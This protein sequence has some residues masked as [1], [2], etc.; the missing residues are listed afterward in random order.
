MIEIRRYVLELF[1]LQ[2][3]IKDEL[4]FRINQGSKISKIGYATN[5][6]PQTLLSAGELG[7]DLLVTH[8]DA[9]DFVY[10]MK[11]ACEKKL[12]ELGISH[13]FAH[14]PLD[15]A[16]F[17]TNESLVTKLGAR[18]VKKICLENGLYCGRVAEFETQIPL[19]QLVASVEKT[20]EEK[21]SSWNN[22]KT[23]IRRIGVV[24]GGGTPTRY[25]R[26]CAENGCDVY[27]TGEKSL[28]LIEY[29]AFIGMDLVVGSHTFTELPGTESFAKKIGGRFGLETICV[30]EEHTEACGFPSGDNT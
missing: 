16:D 30:P 13:L 17:G 4:G 27:I 26:E 20:C 14:L 28:Y 18:T 19:A 3:E 8:H 11:E 25:A 23:G 12:A 6:T 15:A 2:S 22:R 21:V 5:L 1:G 7:V 24:S 9:W 10:G 29:A